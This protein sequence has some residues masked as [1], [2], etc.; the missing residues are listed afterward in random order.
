[1]IVDRTK[2]GTTWGSAVECSQYNC[3]CGKNFKYYL[4]SKKDWTIPKKQNKNDERS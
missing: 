1:M 2:K 4:S 3:R